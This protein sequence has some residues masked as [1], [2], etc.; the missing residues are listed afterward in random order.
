MDPRTRHS[1]DAYDA[2][3]AAY[4][5]AWWNRRPLDAI[6]KFSRLAGRGALVIDIAGGPALDVRALRDAGLRVVSGDRSQEAMRIGAALFPKKP[7]ACWDFR[8]LPFAGGV[9]GGVWAP[10][11]LQHLPRSEMRRAL[12]EVRRVHASGPIFLA[13]REGEGDLEP[14]DDPPVGQVYATKVSEAELKAL[15]GDQGYAM[16]EVERRP[17][18]GGRRDVTWLHG[19]GLLS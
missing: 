15:L 2:A 6:R 7:L 17:D 1:I 12:A 16:I 10:A 11:A 19:W 3:A 5:E 14:V 4:Q 13:F 9:F 8:R 18:P